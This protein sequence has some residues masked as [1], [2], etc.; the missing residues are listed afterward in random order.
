MTKVVRD[1]KVAV[2][3]SP[4]YGAGWSTWA[5][6]SE[7]EM[8]LYD[9]DIVQLVLDQE[10]QLITKEELY[11]RVQQIWQLKSY[12]SYLSGQELEIAW[13]PEG[14]LFRVEEY[15]GNETVIMQHEYNW[16]VA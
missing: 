16:H 10:A 2:L 5:E 7:R 13:I 12:E 14:E 6:S 3:Y 11:E 1:G 15:D 4:G 9:P 8:I